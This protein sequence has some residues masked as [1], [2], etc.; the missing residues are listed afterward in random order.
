MK[1]IAI[2]GSIATGKSLV[3]NYLIKKGYPLVDTDKL[4]RLVVQPDSEGLNQLVSAFGSKILQEDGNLDRKAFAKI[5][6][7]DEKSRALADSIL[8]PLISDLARTRLNQYEREG[9]QIA[10][11]D[12]P[13]YYEGQ[14]DIVVDSVWLVYT[15]EELQKERLMSRNNID[16]KEA[17]NLI[18][19]QLSI[20][21]KARL[22]DLI[23]DNT[24]S[25]QAT[26]QQVDTLLE[27]LLNAE[28]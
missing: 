23:I 14:A 1:I 26:Y 10:F 19:N 7:N 22:A 15:N 8:H 24:S 3:S 17:Q 13:L 4:S 16:A 21:E 12:I 27:K 9:N 20:E 11:V 18:N 6:F 28:E 25:K 5:I 2:T